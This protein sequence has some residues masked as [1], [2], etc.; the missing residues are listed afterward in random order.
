MQRR[1]HARLVAT[2][3]ER[4]QRANFHVLGNFEPTN[5]CK[6]KPNTNAYLKTRARRVKTLSSARD[7]GIKG[8]ND[9]FDRPWRARRH[10]AAVRTDDARN[11]A[12]RCFCYFLKRRILRGAVVRHGDEPVRKDLRSHQV[13]GTKL[14]QSPLPFLRRLTCKTAIQKNL[15]I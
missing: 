13:P 6:C 7:G 4:V 11:F 15:G 2:H 9:D 1:A 5:F 14:H 3:H 12:K 10:A 8:T